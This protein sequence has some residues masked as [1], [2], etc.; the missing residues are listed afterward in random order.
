MSNVSPFR[1]VDAWRAALG[2][3]PVPLRATIEN[4]NQYVL[5]NGTTGN[6][7]LD[8]VGGIDL[9]SRRAIAWSCD[10]GHYIT[11]VGEDIVLNR[12]EKEAP[13]ERYSCRSVI[14]RLHEFHRHLEQTTSD[15]S[16]T[17]IAHVLRIFRRI[18][19]V[20]GEENNGLRSLR[21]LL[22]LLSSAA[23]E[24][25][26]LIDRDFEIWGL[27]PEIVEPLQDITE[28]TWRPLYNDL[29]GIGRYD[30]LR[31]DFQ[32]LLRHASGAVFQDAHLEA[33]IFPY[34]GLPGF[35]LPVL[36]D[37]KA[38]PSET[39][40]Y[41]TPPALARTLAEE[42]T[43]NIQNV[44]ERGLLLF[45]PACG[46]GELLKECL[47]LLKLTGYP[48][49]VRAVGWDRSPGA[50]DM[51]RFVLTWEKR[52]WLANQIEIEVGQ[53]DSVTAENWPSDVDILLMNP[54]FKS[55][56]LMA[57]EEQ[58]TVSRIL[59]P[60]SKPNLAMAF[61]RRALD[62]LREGGMLAMIVPNSL[63]EGKS[64]KDTREAMA[65]ALSPQLVA[66][67][68]DQSIFSRALVDAGMYVGK[69][70]PAPAGP[71]AFLWADSRQDSL[72]HA[73]RG[74]RRWRGSEIEP[75]KGEGFSVYL[76][77]DISTTGGPW[78][79]RGYDAWSHYQLFQHSEK[80]LPAKRMFDI[81]QGIRLGNDVFIVSREYVQGLRKN[82]RRFFRPAVMNPSIVDAK[83]N[84][85]YYAFYPYTD[86]LPFI[87]SETELE[88]Q[89]PQYFK[90][91]LLPAKTV[92][93][94]RK[95][96]TRQTELNWWDLLWPRTW[97][98]E[99]NPKIVSKYFGGRRSF[100]FDGAG[101]FVVVVGNAWLL[102]K[103]AVGDMKVEI[104]DEE[105]Y[106]SV[107]AYLS[108]AT[109][110]HLL[111]YVSVQVS[112][113]QLDLSNRYVGELPVPNV[114]TL[115]FADL[116]ELIQVGTR[117]SRGKIDRWEDVDELVVSILNR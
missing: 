37:A 59:G 2:L 98:K 54:P 84:D 62:V 67:L 89:V 99:R 33:D 113:G 102:R 51:A 24:Q 13:E 15:R 32:L 49:R 94:G 79:V 5:L 45:D 39:G 69:R 28:A 75:L 25:D 27:T 18:R 88:K 35:E 19:A 70:K 16:R 44:A 47:R 64:G 73:L 34:P 115:A 87:A 82:E 85:A 104:T 72:N 9:N 23:A 42:A 12:W 52:A 46:S 101:E 93:K 14:A 108:S 8:F 66:R 116:S 30:V 95:T 21:V 60:S 96:L 4:Q 92:L 38:V 65:A 10:V 86:G 80:L 1:K 106:L 68:G 57:P 112:G 117:I 77:K 81:R 76:H 48:G 3:L 7:C 71:T 31:P 91:H 40:I 103:G 53:H 41:F 110:Y 6:F 56:Q 17:I 26:R 22:H 36:V 58:E 100:A 20:V 90:E 61:A 50:V 63:L 109:A 43:R 97:Q 55:W 114:A 107:L 11:C 111:E 105:L 83:L 29:S 74:L 78:V